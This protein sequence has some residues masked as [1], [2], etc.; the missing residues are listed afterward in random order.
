MYIDPLL[1][2]GCIVDIVSGCLVD[3]W[4]AIGSVLEV[5]SVVVDIGPAVE[6]G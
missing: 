4:V 1:V 2:G 5:G 3:G 6:G